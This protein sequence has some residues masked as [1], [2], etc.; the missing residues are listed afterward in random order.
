MQRENQE[1]PFKQ[2]KK[3]FYCEG[4]EI[5]EQGAQRGYGVSTAKD[6]QNL[7]GHSPEQQ[8]VSD[9]A[10]ITGVGLS[11][12]QGCLPT[13]ATLRFRTRVLYQERCFRLNFCV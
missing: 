7:S 12:L 10:L 2:A 9:L 6:I 4:D 3:C 8:A 1:I 11:D 5:P 13:S